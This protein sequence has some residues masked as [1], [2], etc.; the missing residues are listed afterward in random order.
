MTT[1]SLSEPEPTTTEPPLLTD[2]PSVTLPLLPTDEPS[3]DVST[4]LGPPP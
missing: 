3:V 1:D 4:S 2:E